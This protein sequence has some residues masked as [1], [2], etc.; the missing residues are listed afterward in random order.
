MKK[1]NDTY[2]I[3][4]DHGYG[5]MKTANCCFPTGVLKSST[6]PSFGGNVLVWKDRY[7]QIG[8]GHKAFAAEKM[9][10]EDYYVL[11][12]AAM[13][14]E[15]GREQIYDAAV[16]IAAG[17]P[18]TWVSQQKDG[19][20][21]YLLQNETVEF[22][23]R[24]KDYRLRIVGADLYPQGFA[25]IVNNLAD[26]SG[27]NMLCDIGN[28]TMNVMFVTN[29]KPDPTRCFTEKFGTHQCMLQVRENL[30]KEHGIEPPEELITQVLRYG[31]A[32]IDAACLK[33]ITDTAREYTGGI[34]RRLQEHGYNSQLMKLY[35]VGGG[36]ALIRNFAEYKPDRVTI[37]GDICATAK[38]YE[39][40]VEMKLLRGDK[41]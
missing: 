29:K 21:Q 40:M 24:R 3:G 33:T 38:G 4:I 31:T 34:F 41:L 30:L 10:D 22:T 18:L 8:A 14:R 17:L 36:G 28:G 15:L 16:F 2:I 19:F 35:V 39:R 20:K 26:F 27:V 23:F 13:A 32:D 11:T 12:L 9:L 6:E 5:N 25:A 7:Y 1:F 37:N